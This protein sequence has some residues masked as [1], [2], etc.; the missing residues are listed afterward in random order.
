MIS[1]YFVSESWL[2]D[3][4]PISRY[5]DIELVKPFLMQA[6]D[7]FIQPVLGTEFYEELMTS[8][9]GATVSSDQ[10]RLLTLVR[11]AVAY[12]A[13]YSALPFISVQLRNA[14]AVKVENPNV[15]PAEKREVDALR[16][17]VKTVG[18]FYTQ[19]VLKFLR[20]NRDLFPTY[21]NQDS[22]MEPS[23]ANPYDSNGIFL[24]GSGD[25]SDCPDSLGWY[26]R[27]R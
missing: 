11:P 17:E 8:V 19:R 3:F 12:Y 21:V 20:D 13:L 10:A 16:S 15:V 22:D 2:K 14:G 23:T 18:D 7:M 5:M 6:Q 9:A 27:N 24:E 26:F 1:A 25:C 4:A